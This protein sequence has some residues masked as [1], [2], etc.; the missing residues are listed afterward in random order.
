MRDL[1]HALGRRSK[2][3]GLG[4]VLLLTAGIIAERAAAITTGPQDNVRGFY[5]TDITS[6]RLT[7]I[8]STA[9]R[10][11]SFRSSASSPTTPT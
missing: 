3:A 8:G 6:S 10:V 7:P 4:V 5:D 2:I 11:S 9:T 1:V